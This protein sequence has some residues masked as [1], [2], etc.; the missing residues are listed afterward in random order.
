MSDMESD[1]L[2]KKGKPFFLL[3]PPIMLLMFAQALAG[4]I[5]TDLLVSR[6]CQI[7]L[8]INHTFCLILDTNSSS[9][10][11]RELETK[12]EPYASVIM[13]AKSLLE[14][15]MPAI[16]SLFVGPW[17]DRGGR[18]PLLLAGFA[19][20]TTMFVMLSFICNWNISPW[21]L[22]IPS[23]PGFG[24]GG[25]CTVILASI[26]HISD[27]TVEKDRTMLLAQLQASLIFGLLL[28]VFIGP[29]IFKY[30]GYTTVFSTA[31]ICSLLA[32]LYTYFFI[33]ETVKD[34]S[35]ES[36][37]GIFKISSVKGIFKSCLV[38]RAGCHRGVIWLAIF[39]LTVSVMVVE[40]HATIGFLFAR[41]RLA[42]NVQQYGYYGGVELL[43]SVIGVLSGVTLFSNVLGLPDTLVVGI[44]LV[45][46][47]SGSLTKAF[48]EEA[49]QFYLSA[50]IGMFA[51]VAG[52]VVRSILSKSIPPDDVGK[53]FALTASMET[54]SPLVGAP[55][56]TLMYSNYL[57]P[58]FP[59]PVYLVSVGFLGSL[60]FA[61][62]GIEILIRKS[63]NISHTILLEEE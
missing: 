10:E 6:T 17:S 42:W 19:G 14:S 63:Q 51:G 1:Q 8:N 3:G 22:L 62:L 60:V 57:P 21:Y 37:R 36:M 28:G 24:M 9:D 49:W 46:N 34:A 25:F 31:A 48:T 13:M 45:S 15:I 30:C 11:A 33:Q 4:N 56:Y 16:I 43:L 29:F 5:M 47:M 41:E 20:F 59:L 18:R 39:T 38:K 26:C 2:I 12:V 55:L 44:A 32:L 35:K 50:G 7:S 23:I 40:G 54:V 27:T 53:V 58:I 61:I 52:P